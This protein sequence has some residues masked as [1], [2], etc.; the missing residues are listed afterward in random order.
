MCS[1]FKWLRS[2]LGG[3]LVCFALL[4]R[5]ECVHLF[6]DRAYLFVELFDEIAE[7]VGKIFLAGGGVVVAVFEVGGGFVEGYGL[8]INDASRICVRFLSG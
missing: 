4:L 1:V 2:G 3:C 7:G 6:N 8:R 5:K